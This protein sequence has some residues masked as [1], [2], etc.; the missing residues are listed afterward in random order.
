MDAVPEHKEDSHP[1]QATQESQTASDFID[2]QLAL[3]AD[4]REILPYKFDKCTNVLGPLRQ[5]VFACLTCSPP[6]ASAAQVYT[7]AGVCY[8]CSISCHGEH[9]LVELFSR[10][11]FVCDCGTSRLPSTSSCTLRSN[12]DTGARGVHSQL[13]A[14][15]NKYNHNFQNHFCACDE[16]YDPH[17]EKGTMFQC[18]GLGTV[19]TGGCGEDWYHPECLVGLGRDWHKKTT[20]KQDDED[21][22]K[23][24]AED[25][26]HPTPPGF[27]NEDDF[28]YL[29]CYKCVESNPWIKQYARTPGFLEPVYRKDAEAPET[30]SQPTQ[31]SVSTNGT[32]LKRK[33]SDSDLDDRPSSPFKRVKDEQPNQPPPSEAPALSDPGAVSETKPTQKHDALPP[34]PQGTFSLFLQS[35]FRE[36]ICHCPKCYPNL[37][38][39][40][41]LVEE[42]E[43]YEPSLSNESES[44]VE[45]AG[46]GGPRS[47]GT[48]SLLDR[49]EA[50]LSNMDRVK[51][52]EGVMVYNHLRDKVKEFLKPYAESGQAVS[53]EDIKAYFEKL[54]GDE[55]AI[56][57]AS[58]KPVDGSGD[59]DDNRREQS[60]H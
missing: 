55:S 47:Q 43:T 16:E 17:T 8:A 4:A 54:R 59:G 9:T 60:G 6:P 22:G 2:Q 39:H 40:P 27:P 13:P 49:G 58:T 56:K 31:D 11:N 51:A 57:D 44:Q 20:L 10:R 50:A 15:G 42:E 35:D 3:E 24:E 30:A 23:E 28:E 36:H 1:I 25:S 29:I 7:P 34:A 41:Q 53:A 46:S 18:L 14:P 5:T 45:N 12:P 32:T 21:A 37:I 38:P 52:I 19:E 33:V 48:A 26:E